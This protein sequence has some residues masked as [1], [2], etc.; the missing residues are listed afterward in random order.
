MKE[1]ELYK[2]EPNTIDKG[3]MYT[4]EIYIDGLNA[5]NKRL[6]RVYLPSD[7]DFNNPNKRFPVLY[8]MD[9]KNLFDDHTSF[10][11]EW[12]V[13]ETIEEFI[14]NNKK[15][16]IVVGI[17]SA[18][19]GFERMKEMLVPSVFLSKRQFKIEVKGQADL[20]ADYIVN[21]LK[22]YIDE[23]FYTLKDKDNTGI[24]GSSMGGLFSFYLGLKYKESIGFILSFSPAFLLYKEKEFLNE[25]KNSNLDPNKTGKIFFWTGGINLD[26]EI[27]PL[28]I[29]AYNC[30]YKMGFN[31]DKCRLIYDSCG[32]HNEQSWRLPFKQALQWWK[33]Q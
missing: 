14:N 30:L 22:P 4:K 15:G 25:L 1:F 16:M 23:K 31:S 2:K 28:T 11:G 10:V 6:I 20:L 13:D 32:D 21:E 8:M 19:D 29:K 33:Y 5:D 24:G 7:Y 18:K 27:K 9:G 26:K 12:Q 3:S 17:D